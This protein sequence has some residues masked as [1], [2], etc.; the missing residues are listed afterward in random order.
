MKA[1]RKF[2]QAVAMDE[3]GENGQAIEWSY[4]VSTICYKMDLAITVNLL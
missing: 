4:K 2:E 3:H 1:V